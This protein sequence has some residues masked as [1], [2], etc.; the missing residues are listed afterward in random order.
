MK[1]EKD[2]A[3]VI[4]PRVWFDRLLCMEFETRGWVGPS[5]ACC[6]EIDWV[7]RAFD[8]GYGPHRSRHVRLLGGVALPERQT[9]SHVRRSRASH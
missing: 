6:S 1:E 3:Y 4:N 9:R 7:A 5:G 8:I 2:R